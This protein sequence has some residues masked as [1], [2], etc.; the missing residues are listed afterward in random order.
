MRRLRNQERI[1][2]VMAIEI[3]LDAKSP[4]RAFV[5]ELEG[6]IVPTRRVIFETV[7]TVLSEQGVTFD[8]AAMMRHGLHAVPAH[9]VSDIADHFGLR[10]AART[11]LLGKLTKALADHFRSGAVTMALGLDRI[12]DAARGAGAVLGVLSWQEE[13]AAR[14][15]IEKTGLIRWDPQVFCSPQPDHEF[16]GADVWLKALK[17]LGR[18]PRSAAA[19]CGARSAARSA[20]AA[21]MRVVAVPDEFTSYQDFGGVDAMTDHISD[22]TVDQLFGR[23]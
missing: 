12:L 16:P 11:A 1:N 13:D 10:A 20:L 4:A 19:L 17:V 14:A 6:V 2:D 8:E 23:F 3:S 15:L 22:V 9:M 5:M 7:R 18:G 21:G